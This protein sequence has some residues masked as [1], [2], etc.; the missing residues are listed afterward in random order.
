MLG[1]LDR[2][3][4]CSHLP[5]GVITGECTK[6]SS[7]LWCDKN[8]W[9]NY[10]CA[11][12][13]SSGCGWKP[14]LSPESLSYD[15]KCWLVIA[16]LVFLILLFEIR[17]LSMFAISQLRRGACYISYPE[18]DLFADSPGSDMWRE[19]RRFSLV[20]LGVSWRFV[21]VSQ[22]HSGHQDSENWKGL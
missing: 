3:Y 16:F 20:P 11:K 7:E 17:K 8:S 13:I 2:K 22:G 18:S 21:D 19:N 9:R 12:W 1:I 5:L 10:K 15:Y 6:G 14:T 4:L